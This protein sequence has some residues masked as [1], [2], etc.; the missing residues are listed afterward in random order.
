MSSRKNLCVHPVVSLEKRGDVTDAKCRSLTAPWVRQDR[1]GDP[2]SNLNS[3]ANPNTDS[4]ANLIA[5]QNTNQDG[6]CEFYETLQR[7]D[8]SASIPSG[9]YTLEDLK[10]YGEFKKMCPYFLARKMVRM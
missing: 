4:K 6:L 8:E 7:M 3:N 5:Q 2:N 10:A 1:I 9:V